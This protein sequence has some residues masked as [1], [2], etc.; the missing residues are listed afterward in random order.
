MDRPQ[1]LLLKREIADS[2]YAAM[3]RAAKASALNLRNIPV[4]IDFP[5]GHLATIL[6]ATGAIGWIEL[7]SRQIVAMD[8]AAAPLV[9]AS[10]TAIDTLRHA[11]MVTC[12]DPVHDAQFRAMC[13]L[14]LTARRGAS[15]VTIVGQKTH[16]A[17][18]ALGDGL[19][20][21]AQQL[22]GMSIRD[23]DH[24]D[25]ASAETIEE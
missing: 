24:G 21:R 9:A 23:L 17:A 18:V 7:Q 25:I 15:E 6:R 5:V 16:D 10:L 8:S 13:A 19:V 12:S 22:L 1:L 11:E 20:S 3:D 2:K 14:F 4:R